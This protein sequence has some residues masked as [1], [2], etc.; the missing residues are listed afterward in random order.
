MHKK[1]RKDLLGNDDPISSA[2]DQSQD[3]T[4]PLPAFHPQVPVAAVEA[5]KAG[6]DVQALD[7]AF[8]MLGQDAFVNLCQGF[9]QSVG[10]SNG[11]F[12]SAIDAYK[13]QQQNAKPGLQGAQLGDQ[14]F[15]GPTKDNP[16][17]HTGL[18]SGDNTFVSA[19]PTGIKNLNIADWEKYSGEQLLGT[20]AKA[21]T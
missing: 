19:T 3:Y 6:G 12:D 17:G 7:K 4:A 13:A 9:V 10:G 21:T 16:Y 2:I 5:I 8:K 20:V 15:F 18:I 11:A 1:K 14:V